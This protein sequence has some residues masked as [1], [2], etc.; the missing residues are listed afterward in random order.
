M[1]FLGGGGDIFVLQEIS[2]S[3]G[4]GGGGGGDGDS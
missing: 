3:G 1:F 4:G 2:Y